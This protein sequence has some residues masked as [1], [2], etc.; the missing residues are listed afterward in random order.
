MAYNEE[1]NDGREKKKSH[2]WIQKKGIK[3]DGRDLTTPNS[4]IPETV[5][6]IK[7]TM[8]AK[9][10]AVERPWFSMAPVG[11]DFDCWNQ[12]SPMKIMAHNSDPA[13]RE[14]F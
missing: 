10:A 1:R 3:Y 11:V 13:L 6:H 12:S 9:A 14:I 8:T 5:A 7:Y 4:N 2:N